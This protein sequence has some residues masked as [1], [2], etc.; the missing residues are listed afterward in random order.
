MD[1]PK[2]VVN[3][4]LFQVG[5]FVT[6]LSAAHGMVW[7]AGAW[8]ALVLAVHFGWVLPGRRRREALLI[9]T[10]VLA[11]AVADSAIAFA[12]LLAFES[13]WP[14]PWIEPLWMM[15]LWVNFTTTVNA[16]MAWLRGRWAVAVAFGAV[17][18][19]LAYWAGEKL[20]A[21]MLGEPLWLAYAALAV[22]W[23]ALLP[24][25]YVASGA[26]DRALERREVGAGIR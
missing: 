20:G 22:A 21:M 8:C 6:V 12:G 11:G 13:A 1:T 7:L 4:L 23:G 2:K 25:L 18:G 19:P 26:L 24:L 9:A 14:I 3:Y 10:A 17:G 15:M 16:S 5:W